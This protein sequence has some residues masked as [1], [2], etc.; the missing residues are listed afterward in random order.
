MVCYDDG[1]DDDDA[2]RFITGF[3]VFGH[4]TGDNAMA[5]LHEAI[6]SHGKLASV[7]PDHSSQFY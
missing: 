6:S 1:D 3:D 4:A 2:S 7:L 5:V